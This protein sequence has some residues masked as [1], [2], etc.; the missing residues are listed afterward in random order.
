MAADLP[1]KAQSLIRATHAHVTQPRIRVLALLL[2][3]RRA[4]SHDEIMALVPSGEALDRVTL[5]R[6]LEWLTVQGL[7]RRSIADDR[8]Y[9]F[10]IAAPSQARAPR[11]D[12]KC[13]Q[14]GAVRRVRAAAAPQVRLPRGFR[15]QYVETLIVGTCSDCAGAH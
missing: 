10:G 14:C 3:Q 12:F 11:A 4:L 7:A 9:R 15:P 8:V 1:A 13:N 5:Y 6:V 2:G